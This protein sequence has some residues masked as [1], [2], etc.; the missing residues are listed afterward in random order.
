VAVSAYASPG[1]VVSARP[2]SARPTPTPVRH[3]TTVTVT[4]DTT[5]VSLRVGDTLVIDFDSYPWTT[6]SSSDDV[7]LHLVGTTTRSDGSIAT[8]TFSARAAGRATVR[9]V[10][11]YPCEPQ[12]LPAD[13][14]YEL[15]VTVTQ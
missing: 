6:P 13:R 7:V 4:T 15:A 8:A 2:S 14:A 12:C 9:S 5:S 11:H 1:H 3:G 10:T